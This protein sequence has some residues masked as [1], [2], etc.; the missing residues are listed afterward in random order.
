MCFIKLEIK[1]GMK[2]FKIVFICKKYSD[3]WLNSSVAT[4]NELS[5]PCW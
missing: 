2:G 3:I 4:F 5:L 1:S